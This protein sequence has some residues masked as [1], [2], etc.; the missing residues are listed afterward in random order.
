[1]KEGTVFWACLACWNIGCGIAPES[2]STQ[3]VRNYKDTSFGRGD[4][5]IDGDGDL[6]EDEPEEW[7]Q[8]DPS[9]DEFI[10]CTCCGH[11]LLAA[12]ADERATY[13]SM[14]KHEKVIAMW[15][16]DETETS[17]TLANAVN[18]GWAEPLSNDDEDED[19]DEPNA[20]DE[21]AHDATPV[22]GTHSLSD[23]ATSLAAMIGSLTEDV[24]P[25]TNEIT[26][27]FQ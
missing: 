18:M 1:M 10:T 5:T 2:A 8:R 16:D 4:V 3:F 19:D 12:K 22:I 20:Y 6:A 7:E 27:T 14:L 17:Y 9:P 21:A 26:L 25:D 23:D 24:G 13:T 15:Q 11:V